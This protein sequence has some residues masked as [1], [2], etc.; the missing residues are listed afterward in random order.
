M[1]GAA[2]R[3]FAAAWGFTVIDHFN[4]G[5]AFN[6]N[7]YASHYTGRGH[8]NAAGCGLIIPFDVRQANSLVPAL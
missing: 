4:A 5:H 7:N 6:G 8:S 1:N 3:T 2:I